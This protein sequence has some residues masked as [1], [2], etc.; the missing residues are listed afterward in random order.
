VHGD[1]ELTSLVNEERNVV[2][3]LRIDIEDSSRLD[4]LVHGPNREGHT[5]CA[6]LRHSSE[7][8]MRVVYFRSFSLSPLYSYCVIQL[9][10]ISTEFSNK[11][12]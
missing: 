9:T 5:K 12:K 7:G 3:N 2:R 6:R 11:V 4:L 1:S 8:W 10:S